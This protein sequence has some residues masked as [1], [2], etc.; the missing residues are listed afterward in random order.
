M[1]AA[2]ALRAG[3]ERIHTQMYGYTAPEE[4]IQITTFRAEAVAA[5]AK[6]PI[7]AF[8]PASAPVEESIMATREVWLPECGG[9]TS[10]PVYD[11]E[12]LGPGHVIAGPAIVEQMDSTTLILAGQTATVDAYLNLIV[13]G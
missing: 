12:T 1:C 6:A 5:V 9:F 13:E 4:P 10:A 7:R 3:F 2:P 8:P 11:R